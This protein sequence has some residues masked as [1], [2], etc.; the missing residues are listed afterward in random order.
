ML[1]SLVEI[2]NGTWQVL[3]RPPSETVVE[4]HKLQT[5]NMSLMSR[6]VSTS[7]PVLIWLLLI[8]RH[9]RE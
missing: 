7:V 3:Q 1:E 5:V 2:A 9:Y 4:L 6:F 8:A